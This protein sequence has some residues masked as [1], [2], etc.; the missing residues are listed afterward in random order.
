LDARSGTLLG[1][2]QPIKHDYHDWDMDAAPAIIR[3][4]GG[5]ELAVAGAKDGLVYGIDRARIGEVVRKGLGG[6]SSSKFGLLGEGELPIQYQTAATRRLNVDVPLNDQQFTRFA[7]GQGGGMVWNGPAYHPE[8]NLIY[9][10]MV[11]W[12]T[13]VKLAPVSTLTGQPGHPWLGTHDSNFGQQ[14]PKSQW[15]GDL[16]ALDADSGKIRWQLHTSTPLLGGVTAWY[17][18]AISMETSAPTTGVPASSYGRT[19][20]DRQWR[21]ASSPIKQVDVNISQWRPG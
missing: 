1:Y 4:R 13:S 8:L 14:D 19:T 6:P 5:R 10:A 7:P 20:S 2:V 15:G 16:T 12:A 9:T 17:F 21:P 18:V 3:T 11:D